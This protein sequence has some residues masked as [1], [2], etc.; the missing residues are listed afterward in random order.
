MVATC[1]DGKP[2]VAVHLDDR[3]GDNPQ[4]GPSDDNGGN[5]GGGGGGGG[6]TD[7]PP[8]HH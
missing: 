2:Q 3:G 7:D 8:G 4:P 1:V 5:R 6:G